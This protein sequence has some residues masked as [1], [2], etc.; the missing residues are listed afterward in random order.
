MVI[1]STNFYS[2]S[3]PVHKLCA[4]ALQWHNC[5]SHHGECG[6]GLNNFL[7][8]ARKRE[9]KNQGHTINTK[10]YHN[11]PIPGKYFTIERCYGLSYLSTFRLS[12]LVVI[13]AIRRS[14][15]LFPEY[16]IATA[17]ATCS[18]LKRVAWSID[19]P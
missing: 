10:S 8:F 13:L 1:S 12:F 14:F 5:G 17:R 19:M 6:T 18:R 16:A 7:A 11:H 4:V 2:L 15:F 9:R 3:I